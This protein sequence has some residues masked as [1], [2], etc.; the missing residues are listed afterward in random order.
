MTEA[1][2]QR[3]MLAGRYLLHDGLSFKQALIQ[4]GYSEQ[5]A[6]CPK[7]NGLSAKR[8]AE[9]ALKDG[10]QVLPAALRVQARELLQI[11]LDEAKNDPEKVTLTAAARA[12][13]TVEKVWS[14]SDEGVETD[15]RSFADRLKWLI[16]FLTSVE[17]WR[18]AQ[19]EGAR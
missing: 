10:K 14:H 17:R 11:K 4:A 2:E 5:T 1:K 3:M 18:Y 7:A 12:V 9:L 19:K 16:K 6:R 13:E 15:A 8:C